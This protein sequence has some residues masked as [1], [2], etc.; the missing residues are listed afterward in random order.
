[1]AEILRQK[2][3]RGAWKEGEL[4][5]TLTDLAAEF[6]VAK[7]TVRQ[8][9][10]MLEEEGL[11][12]PKRGRGTT[13]LPQV[14][15]QR[16]LK[17]ETRLAD[18]IEMY[19]GDVPEL[20]PLEDCA[21]DLPEDVAFGTPA[22]EGY[23]MIRRMHARDGQ[24]YCIITLYFALPVFARH[25]ARLRRELALPVLFSEPDIDVRTARQ[26]MTISK[27]GIETARLLDLSI[28]DPIAD[29]RRV[30]CD[31][32]GRILYL[33]DVIYRGDYVRLDMD[34]MA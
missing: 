21:A 22:P 8:A 23:H 10:K 14:K 15:A 16:P 34:L 28:G 2:I 3:A 31:G 20:V 32:A 1:M 17:V 11:V 19:S 25:E 5:P 12:A 27:C 29:V 13:V 26:T 33:A 24:R 30:L 7:V 4:L 6:G 18:L 9:V